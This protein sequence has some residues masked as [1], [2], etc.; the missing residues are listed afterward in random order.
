MSYLINYKRWK[1]LNE[2]EL[3]KLGSTG[4]DVK[5][6]QTTLGITPTGNFD[7]ATRD[8]VIQFQAKSKDAAGT[9]LKQD[10]IVG[11]MTRQALFGESEP[12]KKVS[13][14]VGQNAVISIPEN[15][16]DSVPVFVLYP[17]IPVGG[18]I[19]KDYLPELIS[20][21]V[22]EW[23]SKYAIVVPNQHT[24]QWTSVKAEYE[25]ALAQ[26]NLKPK[27]LVIG[28]FSGSGNNSAD[29]T[30]NLP[31]IKP[32]AVLLMDPT[33]GQ[34]LTASISQLGTSSKIIMQYNPSNWGNASYYTG[35]HI[36]GLEQAVKNSGGTLEKISTGHMK[37]PGNLL[38]QHKSEIETIVG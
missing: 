16:E 10:G 18:K 19:G 2:S 28:I 31:S 21:S 33:P 34:N 12:S 5:K 11:P 30:K 15:V 4:E 13:A 37:I 26:R 9:P 38:S 6:V 32:L 25:A 36:A 24:T 1:S 17:G 29:I 14:H 20:A 23:Y 35:P 7:D 27:N 8:T 22:P 3:L